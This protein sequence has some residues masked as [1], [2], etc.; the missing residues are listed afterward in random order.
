MY[1]TRKYTG[2]NVYDALQDRLR[3]LFEELII[4]LFLFQEERTAV[5]F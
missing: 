3:L 2:Q 1:M 5:C 4:S